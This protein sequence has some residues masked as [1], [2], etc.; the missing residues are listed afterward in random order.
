MR[1][2][3]PTLAEEAEALRIRHEL[4]KQTP[5]GRKIDLRYTD[6]SHTRVM[7]SCYRLGELSGSTPYD[8]TAP[9]L[10]DTVRRLLREGWVAQDDRTTS[11]IAAIM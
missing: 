8:I 1:K 11:I 2:D 6:R 10:K 3:L 5:G 7:V 9:A 4:A